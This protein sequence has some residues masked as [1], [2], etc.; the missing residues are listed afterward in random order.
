MAAFGITVSRKQPWH[1][2]SRGRSSPPEPADAHESTALYWVPVSELFGLMTA[3]LISAQPSMLALL[4]AGRAGSGGGEPLVWPHLTDAIIASSQFADVSLQTNGITLHR[5]MTGP[6][7]LGNLSVL[8]VSVYSDLRDQHKQIAGV[9]S[10]ERVSRN[11]RDAATMRD[12]HGWKLTIGAKILVD[13]INYSRLPQIIRYYRALGTDS[14]ALREVQ[15]A[16]HGQAGQERPIGLRDEQRQEIRRQATDPDADPALLFFAHALTGTATRSGPPGTATTPPT[17]TSPA[18][19]PKERS[20]SAT[21]KSGTG[22]VGSAAVGRAGYRDIIVTG[23]EDGTVQIWNAVTGAPV[24]KPLAGH[25]ST[26][27]SIAIGRAGSK[28]IIVTGSAD[29]PMIVREHRP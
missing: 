12:R 13:Q 10:F 8:S 17:G 25:G 27:T 14:V 16:S 29:K 4:Y 6:R 24:G 2:A 22:G 1:P 26:V 18:L 3:G 15:G 9:D 11:I 7:A 21:P 23:S 19:T 5:L 28:S 20:T